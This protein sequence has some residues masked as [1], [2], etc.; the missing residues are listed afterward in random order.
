MAPGQ[1]C[2]PLV[3]QAVGYLTTEVTRRKALALMLLASG[4]RQQSDWD[5]QNSSYVQLSESICRHLTARQENTNDQIRVRAVKPGALMQKLSLKTLTEQLWES[6]AKLSEKSRDRT[7]GRG[8]RP[9]GGR[10]GTH[11][12]SSVCT[13]AWRASPSSCDSFSP[14]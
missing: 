8:S 2:N 4:E 7:R 11:W 6:K 12:L 3:Q 10:A 14:R 1:T 13:A 5:E 9:R